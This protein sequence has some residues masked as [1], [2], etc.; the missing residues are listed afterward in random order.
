MTD[1]KRKV[2][3][4][5]G[6]FSVGGAEKL[7][8]HQIQAMDPSR[9]ESKLITIFE[10]Q[11][12]TFA[13]KVTIDECFRFRSVKDVAALFRLFRYL[14]REKFDIVVTSLFS[15]NLLVRVAAICARVPC[16]IAYE[17]N[18]YPNKNRWQIRMDRMLSRWTNVI[19]TDSEV[20]RQ[21]T[22]AQEHIPLDKF[23]TLHIPPLLERRTPRDPIQLK[24]ELGVANASHIIVTVSRLVSDKGHS[25]L[26]NAAAQ[27][28]ARHPR[29]YFLIVGWGPLE[30]DLQR[31]IDRLGIAENVKLTGRMDI[32]DMLPLADIYVD[33]AVSTDLPIAIMEAMREKKAIVASVVG[34]IPLFVVSGETGFSV[35]PG[36]PDAIAAAIETLIK[37]GTMRARFGEAAG[38]KVAAYS[39]PAYMQAFQKLLEEHAR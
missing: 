39:F 1:R 26:V 20:A 3:F 38:A 6:R 18:I 28:L 5:I 33:P 9:F 2:L 36:N 8:V 34:D 29:V 21:F 17:H 7:L 32:Q 27:I 24:K 14:R 12:D 19:I 31:Q 13:D 15:A 37:D 11:A 16:I 25:H 4:A 23:T 10:E 35:Q 30:G 22:A